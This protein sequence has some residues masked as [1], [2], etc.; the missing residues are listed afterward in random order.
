[1]FKKIKKRVL[2]G[3]FK[4]QGACKPLV[5][6]H[7]N[8]LG[9]YS[10]INESFNREPVLIVSLTSYRERFNDLPQTLYSLLNQSL[11]PDKIILWLDQ[12]SEDFADLPYE[13]TQF[14]KN[15]LEI[16]FVKNL[17]SY[18]K[19]FYSF[20]E[21]SDS[22]LVTA[23]DDIYY[24]RDWLKKLYISYIA[25]PEDIHVHKAYRITSE[26]NK[27]SLLKNIKMFVNEESARYDNFIVGYGGVLYPPKCFTPEVFR[28]DIFFKYSP[29]A[30]DVWFWFMALVKGR[31]I[32]VVKNHIKTFAINNI[33]NQIN[34]KNLVYHNRNGG[35]DRQIQNLM[36]FYAS[37][38]LSKLE[39]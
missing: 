14:I 33:F 38:I 7:I 35:Y 30:D 21:Y 1:M 18:T 9:E 10:G 6:F 2:N 32:R 24:P 16:K 4:I 8:A 27:L 39:L 31:K 19:V 12:E 22:I 29:N 5:N 3:R 37:N 25:H 15:G 28:Q 13:I 26:N 23:D 36:K 34:S 11:K 20:K 17:R